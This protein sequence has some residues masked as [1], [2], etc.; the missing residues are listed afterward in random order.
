MNFT[1]EIIIIKDDDSLPI[2]EYLHK[3]YKVLKF[4]LV[5]K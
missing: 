5:E 2:Y 3:Y 1:I 4:R